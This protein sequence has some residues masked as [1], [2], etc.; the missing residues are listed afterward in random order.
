MHTDQVRPRML[1][2]LWNQIRESQCLPLMVIQRAPA[3]DGW[4]AVDPDGVIFNVLDLT[5]YRYECTLRG[6]SRTMWIN[7][8][9]NPT[10]WFACEPVPL[11]V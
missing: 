1:I 8:A 6:D 3:D 5:L 11:N 9:R 4:L 2:Q 10:E 7:A